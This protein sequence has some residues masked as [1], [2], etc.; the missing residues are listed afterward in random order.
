MKKQRVNF[1]E[2]NDEEIL[3][4]FVKRFQC[5]GAILLY[6]DADEEYGFAKS[7]NVTGKK[8]AN[9]IFNIL[10]KDTTFKVDNFKPLSIN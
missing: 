4:E 5:D 6:M 1:D 3:K 10:K 8:W 7:R 9:H 2:L